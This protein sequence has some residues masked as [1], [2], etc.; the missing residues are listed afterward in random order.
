M[1]RPKRACKP[2]SHKGHTDD[3]CL[4]CA[5][6]ASGTKP[7]GNAFPEQSKARGE[8]A[9]ARDH[10]QGSGSFWAHGDAP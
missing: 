5:M 4:T 8:G 1:S 3:E 6:A 10:V 2:K 7:L 9:A